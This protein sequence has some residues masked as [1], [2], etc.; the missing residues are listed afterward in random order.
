MEG[1][2]KDNGEDQGPVPKPSRDEERLDGQDI[3]GELPSSPV[4]PKEAKKDNSFAVPTIAAP[5]PP[6]GGLG[7]SGGLGQSGQSPK[8]GTGVAGNFTK[9]MTK[10]I[11]P[12]GQKRMPMS[13]K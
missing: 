4:S 7:E 1:K 13:H 2:R 6:P 9:T 3:E 8:L 10:R 11:K 5:K 12:S